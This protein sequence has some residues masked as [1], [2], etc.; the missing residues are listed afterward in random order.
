[1]ANILLNEMDPVRHK[2]LKTRLENM[3][4]TVWSVNHFHFKNSAYFNTEFD[5]MIFDLDTQ[6][7]DEIIQFARHWQGISILFQ[8]SRLNFQLDFRNWF[9]DKLIE[10]SRDGHNVVDA[11][12]RLRNAE[13][14]QC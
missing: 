7:I 11:V 8:S 6:R 10:K 5:V 9:A 3:G 4:F 1:M 14:K 2:L 12:Q 13:A